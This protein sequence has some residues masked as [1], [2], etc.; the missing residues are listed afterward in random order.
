MAPDPL[1]LDAPA[2][3]ACPAVAA[4]AAAAPMG[5]PREGLLA[6]LMACRLAHATQEE[7]PADPTVRAERAQAARQWLGTLALSLPLR[8]AVARVFDAV[9]AGDAQVLGAAL[10]QMLAT[11]GETMPPE[12]AT[13]IRRLVTRVTA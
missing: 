5:G 11:A 9:A 12:A 8:A 6:V 4:A 3:F 1:A 13:D 10:L 2:A 7:P